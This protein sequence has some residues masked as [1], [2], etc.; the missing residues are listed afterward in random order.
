[1]NDRSGGGIERVFRAGCVSMAPAAYDDLSSTFERSGFD[2]N[3]RPQKNKFNE[4]A[5][6]A[7]YDSFGRV[8]FE[9]Y[10]ENDRATHNLVRS[11]LSAWL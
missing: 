4:R 10:P 2:P 7:N 8:I 3:G 5:V 1:M 6:T 9:C 11:C